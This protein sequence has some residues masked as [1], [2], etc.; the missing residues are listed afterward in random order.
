MPRSFREFNIGL[1]DFVL[2]RQAS[3]QLRYLLNTLWLYLRQ[4]LVEWP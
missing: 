4:G 1:E 2:A 3:Y